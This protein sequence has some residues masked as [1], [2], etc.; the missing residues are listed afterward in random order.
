MNIMNSIFAQDKK[1]WLNSLL[2][3]TKVTFA[4]GIILSFVILLL[5]FS[6][7]KTTTYLT[8]ISARHQADKSKVSVVKGVTVTQLP[9]A[10]GQP[11]KWTALI[12]ASTISAGQHLIEIPKS[13]KGVKVKP[14]A[15]AVATASASAIATSPSS[16]KSTQNTLT[17]TDRQKLQEL[18]KQNAVSS[19]SLALA[20]S[21][22][23]QNKEKLQLVYTQRN[24]FSRFVAYISGAF[25]KLGSSMASV[26]TAVDETVSAPTAPPQPEVTVVDV[27]PQAQVQ[28]QTQTDA[29]AQSGTQTQ[30]DPAVTGAPTTNEQ[31]STTQT[32]QDVAGGTGTGSGGT[33]GTGGMG[34]N[35]GTGTGASTDQTSP[36]STSVGDSSSSISTTPP[37]ISSTSTPSTKT[38][39]VVVEYQTPTP[40]IAE[41]TTD[42]GKIV[43]VSDSA[44]TVAGQPH[45]TNVLAFT[46]IPPI[47]RVG[48]ESKIKIK[49]LNNNGQDMQFHAYDLDGDGKLDYVEWTVPHLSTQTFEIIFIT[50]ALEMD[51][52]GEIVG[53]IYDEVKNQDNTWAI[54][55]DGHTVR[56]TFEKFLTNKNDNT[57]YARPAQAGAQT[58]GAQ[59]GTQGLQGTQGSSSDTTSVTTARIDVYPVYDGVASDQSV[60]TFQNIDTEKMYKVLLTNLPHSTNTFDLKIIGT[61][62]IDYI[63]DPTPIIVTETF[64]DSTKIAFSSGVVVD[65]TNGA[66]SLAASSSWACGSML[67]DTRD[68]KN[69]STVLIGSQ[70]WM[71]QNLNIGTMISS[72]SST[73]NQ[74]TNCSSAIAIQK[75]CYNNDLAQCGTGGGLYQWNQTMCG[76]VTAGAQGI[77]P[78]GWHVPTH[79]EFTL[80]ERTTCT[81][82][83]CATDFPYDMSTTGWRG[84]NE[85]TTMKN[86]SLSFRGILAGSR[87]ADGSFYDGGSYTIFWSSVGS[88]GS[89][90]RRLLYSG[91]A[92]VSRLTLAVAYGFSVR[93]LKN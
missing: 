35:T 27:L 44:G 30:T 92:T 52:N 79:D 34:V 66:I 77:C 7:I 58:G 72:T 84:T 6:L 9:S 73:S 16:S 85:G 54:I 53:D 76:S 90:W 63:V 46:N 22:K 43:T 57:I 69:Y 26:A 78:T 5:A 39:D 1:K 81:S 51:E 74:G 83:T 2:K 32:S 48:Q 14:A 42:T 20:E 93:C 23:K 8:S 82:G 61:L 45:T 11:I 13:A 55:P 25:S 49:W 37:A 21:L 68:G 64:H 33:T 4:L 41:A 40:T 17:K 3:K 24:F 59:A 31:G 28:I 71:Q 67:I 75:Y 10:P 38:T 50:K 88:G 36:N 86:M 12:S 60:A 70:C 19:E 29:S 65:T 56:V 89:A 18:S 80:L 62:Q 15:S 87:N 91:N 47:Y